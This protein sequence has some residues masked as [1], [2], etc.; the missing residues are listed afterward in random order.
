MGFSGIV[1][2]LKH[3]FKALTGQE[4][5]DK[6]F[7]AVNTFADENEAI[8]AFDKSK[9][10]LFNVNGW[11]EMK[12]INS[13]F[14]LHDENG[15]KTDGN[16]K[17]GYFIKIELPGAKIEN[18]VKVTDVKDEKNLAEFIVHPSEKPKE[19]SNREA[20]VKH[21]FAKEASSTFRVIKDGKTIKAFEIGKNE[22]INNND[23]DSGNRTVINTLIAEGG[24]AGFQKI[25][26]EKLTKYLIHLEEE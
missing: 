22:T 6:L 1:D 13:T 23:E 9:D 24:W 18:W 25:Q 14:I 17:T 7:E 8:E 20:E 19:K 26:W 12:G 21:F 15:N 5:K 11:S 3:E 2:K 16:V 10:K 4:S